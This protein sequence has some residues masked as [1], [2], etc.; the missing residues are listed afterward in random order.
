MPAYEEPESQIDRIKGQ[1]KDVTQDIPAYTKQYFKSLFPI[2]GWIGRYNTT[3]FIGDFIAGLTVALVC[4]PQA[5]SYANKLAGLPPQFGLY[6]CFIGLFIY[7]LFATSKDVT[8]GPTAVLSLLVGQYFAS[9]L[10]GSK[11]GS[12]EQITFAIT[13]AFWTGIFQTAVGLLRLGLVVDFVPIPV[14]AG[15]TTGA[16]FQIIISQIAGLLGI[17]NINTN[18]APYQVLYDTLSSINTVSQYDAFFGVFSMVT[19]LTI[20]FVG[21]LRNAIVLIT[22]TGISYALKDNKNVVFTIVKTIPYGLSDVRQPNTSLSYASFI[23]PAIPSVFIVSIL[24]H[25]AVVKTYGRVNGYFTDNNQEVVA[26]GLTNLIASFV[27]GFPATG[28]FS[29]SAIKSASGV[30]TPLGTFLTGILVVIALF[31]LTGVFYY[32]PSAVLSAIII[33]AIGEIINFKILKGLWEVELA[34]FLGFV[35]AFIVTLASSLETGIYASVGWSVLVLL[36]RIARPTVKVLARTAEGSWVDPEAEGFKKESAGITTAPQGILV[37]KIEESLTYPNSGYF[38]DRLKDTVIKNYKYTNAAHL[39][40]GDRMWC[41]DTQ[42]RA[43]KRE[44]DGL[45]DL[46]GLR[47]VVLDF[48]AVNHVDYT[49]LQALIDIRWTTVPFFFVNVKRHEL[50]ALIRVPL[51]ESGSEVD[52]T[53]GAPNTTRFALPK[54][55]K[56]PQQIQEEKDRRLLALEY[57]F[58]SVDSAVAAADAETAGILANEKGTVHIIAQ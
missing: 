32:I 9:Y 18:N 49:G 1:I 10:P 8:I 36:V 50:N 21:Y 19:I 2:A 16:G 55:K 54:L 38:V 26:I 23:L 58:Y 46:P 12:N 6:T 3:W 56:T 53:P 27:G 28:S 39:T 17:K 29:R 40:N 57:F 33:P 37:F 4:I 30:R 25:I 20:K 13:L 22:T 11:Y 5:I 45:V 24:E 31:T 48:S 41:D 14:I 42:E 47:A 7:C 51:V 15:F 44:K 34:D 43:Q 35:I 52:A